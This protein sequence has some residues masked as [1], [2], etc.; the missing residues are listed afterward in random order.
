MT[1]NLITVAAVKLERTQKMKNRAQI[2]KKRRS[3]VLST[4][5]SKKIT[6]IT[7]M[8]DINNKEQL[9]TFVKERCSLVL[10][11]IQSLR[12]KRDKEIQCVKN[13]S[14]LIKISENQ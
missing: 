13:V 4:T 10:Q 12:A 3:S 7:K 2:A 8:N 9:K 14:F 11:M 1:R 5:T 6:D